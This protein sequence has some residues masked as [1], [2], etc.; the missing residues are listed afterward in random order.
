MANAFNPFLF[1]HHMWKLGTHG[2][3]S[4]RRNA[5]GLPATRVTGR[6]EPTVFIDVSIMAIVLH[7]LH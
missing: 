7:Y 3:F 2:I 5:T 6:F 1:H 4:L